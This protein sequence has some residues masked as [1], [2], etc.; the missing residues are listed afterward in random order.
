[1]AFGATTY[2]P[3]AGEVRPK[4]YV[5]DAEGQI[6]GRLATCVASLLRG[7]TREEFTPSLCFG[8]HVIV[9][10]AAKIHMTGRKLEQKVYRRYSGYPGGLKE[11]GARRLSQEKPER[12]VREAVL[13][14]LPKTK[15][16]KAMGHNLL[17]YADGKHPHQAQKPEATAV[18]R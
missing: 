10:N 1:M 8:D 15:L 6:L 12:I 17:V 16:G 9:V 5:V 18:T 2:F 14:M 4:W 13:G 11:V 7:K 3:R